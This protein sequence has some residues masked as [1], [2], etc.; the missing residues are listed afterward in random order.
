MTPMNYNHG[1]IV[2]EGQST[3]MPSRLQGLRQ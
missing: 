3:T 1:R 2:V